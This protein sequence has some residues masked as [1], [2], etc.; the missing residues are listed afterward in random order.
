[1]YQQRPTLD[2][3][4]ARQPGLAGW[5]LPLGAQVTEGGVRF[6][7]WCS[8][9]RQ[10][11][12][13]LRR[14]GGNLYVPME[15]REE[16][17]FQVTLPEAGPGSLYRYRIDRSVSY[18][19]P[20]SR[21]QPRGVHG[22]SQVVDPDAYPWSIPDPPG[23][24]LDG[25]VIY[26][27]HVG[28]FT[29]RGTYRA[30]A[31]QLPY[32]KE[33]GVN[34]IELMPIHTASGR[35]NWGYDGVAL[36]A[37]YLPY[38]SPQ[39]L[40]AFVDRAHQLGLYVLLD[41]VF[42]HLGPEGNYLWAFA[43]EYFTHR[44]DTPWGEAINM[45]HPR[46]R[47]FFVQNALYWLLEYRF[48][49]LRFDATFM[50]FDPSPRHVM[51]ELVETVRARVPRPV[52]LIAEDHRNQ[53]SV[54]RPEG[55]GM[56]MVW[57][58]DFHHA[59]HVLLTGEQHGFYRDYRGTAEEVVRCLRQG[60]LYQGQRSTFTGQARGSPVTDEPARAF[61]FYLQNHDLTGNRPDGKRLQHLT[62][63]ERH[64]AA[65]ALF[66]LAPQTPLLFM[67]EEFGA[68]T[69]FH[70][71]T[72]HSP[73]LGSR[74]REG[75][76]VEYRIFFDY[77]GP[78]VDPQS[79]EAMELSRLRLQERRQN[80]RL[81]ELYR[82]LLRLRREDPVLADQS[83]HRLEVEALGEDALRMRRWSSAGDRLVVASFGPART[84]ELDRP[85]QVLLATDP[86]E[87]EGRRLRLAGPVTVLL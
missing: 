66:L 21:L 51:A 23:V 68:S 40:K 61:V 20:C 3:Q 67:G 7:V 64:R 34:A 33:L 81:L 84:L 72:D 4:P 2:R 78:T 14:Q 76:K 1:M 60:F 25:L 44:F 11:D 53:V 85:R 87:L 13:E 82:E 29:A 37:P 75:R 39:E 71:F 26:E 69:P 45:A 41:V 80:A 38:G 70:Y 86:V 47:Q 5:Q 62:S 63:P 58:D 22:P 31:D 73:E 74:V 50:L 52:A 6:R 77:T 17:L 10:I 65:V 79:P 54:I 83:R 16:N 36:F 8:T 35:R 24:R 15:E 57:T 46:V 49:G 12:V 48:D 30:L 56:D 18:P 42:N 55:W 59:V 28:S 27:L 43:R 9:T 19:D 32:L